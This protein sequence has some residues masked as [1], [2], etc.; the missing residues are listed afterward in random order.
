MSAVDGC[1][2]SYVMAMMMFRS[3]SVH[4]NCPT[5]KRPSVM[6]MWIVLFMNLS[7]YCSASLTLLMTGGTAIFWPR[8]VFRKRS[9]GK[10]VRHGHLE[11][12]VDIS[13][14][15][16][17]FGP[18]PPY[19]AAIDQSPTMF[20]QTTAGTSALGVNNVPNGG[21]FVDES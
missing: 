11:A 14:F 6:C 12:T 18:R 15:G 17:A 20:V 8:D 16:Q 4:F 9:T 21:C 3:L 1:R 13:R 19:L 7:R 10:N 2:Y 5:N